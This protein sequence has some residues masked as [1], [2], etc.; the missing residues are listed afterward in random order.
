[1]AILIFMR[2]TTV[3]LLVMTCLH[4]ALS[5]QAPARDPLLR[6]MDHIA[7]QQLDRRESAIAGIRGVADAN[8]RK[9]LVRE[10]L[11]EILGGLPNYNGP[12]NSRI[13]GRI[14][15]EFYT[16]EKVIFESLPGFYVTANLYRLN[17]TCRRNPAR[18]FCQRATFRRAIPNRRSSQPISR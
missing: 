14:Q 2:L 13:T 1:M 5:A 3:A 12:L 16:I 9:Q 8:R 10:R 6:W 15:N 17:Q 4:R 7:Q 18:F 11:S